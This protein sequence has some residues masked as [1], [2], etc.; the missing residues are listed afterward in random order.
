MQSVANRNED[1]FLGADHTYNVQDVMRGIAIRAK[2]TSTLQSL[3]YK[4]LLDDYIALVTNSHL[5][6]LGCHNYSFTNLK[7][8]YRRESFVH[9]V[10]QISEYYIL[11]GFECVLFMR[12]F[13]FRFTS[14]SSLYVKCN[15]FSASRMNTLFRFTYEY[16][17]PIRHGSSGLLFYFFIRPFP[18]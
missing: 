3:V 11:F 5:V 16:S 7:V 2:Q 10:F 15:L 6:E 18:R 14:V 4:T 13:L 1:F 9:Y 8:E 12:T 17:F